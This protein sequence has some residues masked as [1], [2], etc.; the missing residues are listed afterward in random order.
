MRVGPYSEARQAEETGKEDGKETGKIAVG[1]F[2]RGALFLS[3]FCVSP[4]SAAACED[5]SY[6]REARLTVAYP[7][8]AW[9][10][11]VDSVSITAI[12]PHRL[13]V[14]TLTPP[15]LIEKP[16]VE[17]IKPPVEV[18]P[19]KYKRHKAR[20][21]KTKMRKTRVSKPTKMKSVAPPAPRV[22]KME[23][24]SAGRRFVQWL[25]L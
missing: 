2:L 22:I 16:E 24:P 13:T 18:Q 21:H 11:P 5:L 14:V 20:A 19:I 4:P 15:P 17:L 12:D 9:S 1:M 3:F 8:S 23:K 10:L 7:C 25:G 6:V